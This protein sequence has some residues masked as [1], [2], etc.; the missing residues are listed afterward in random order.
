MPKQ[1]RK[2]LKKEIERL[3]EH[4]YHLVHPDEM[5][6]KSMLI[7]LEWQKMFEFRK[8]LTDAIESDNLETVLHTQD[9]SKSSQL[10]RR[11]QFSKDGYDKAVIWIKENGLYDEVMSK[12]LFNSTMFVHLANYHFEQ[13]M[14]EDINAGDQELKKLEDED[15]H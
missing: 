3:K 6:T 8:K 13:K 5:P 2:E 10:S 4:I 9:I 1:K 14:M 11:F 12:S 15:A 7:K